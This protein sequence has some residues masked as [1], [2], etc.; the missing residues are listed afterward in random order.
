MKKALVFPGQ[1]SQVVGMGKTLYDYSVTAREVFEEIDDALKTNLSKI[2]FEGPQEELTLT[3][4][5]QPALMAVSIAVFKV[6]NIDAGIP[7]V[8][9][10]SCM[11]GHSL[12][13][14]SALVASESISLSDA[15]RLLR[16]RGRAMQEAVPVGKGAMAALLGADLDLVEKI[17]L[18]TDQN[19]ICVIAND[20]APGQVVISGNSLD[21]VL[22]CSMT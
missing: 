13:E 5:A 10:T 17:I 11:A 2:I 12:G 21:I 20:N 9:K 22:V 19:S 4:N 18:K 1:G 8:D 3:L 16:I 7:L 6:I 15:A 14:Y